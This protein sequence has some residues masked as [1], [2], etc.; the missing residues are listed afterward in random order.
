MYKRIIAKKKISFASLIT[1]IKH[2]TVRLGHPFGKHHKSDCIIE[3]QTLYSELT[4][5][6]TIFHFSGLVL[7]GPIFVSRKIETKFKQK[8]FFW[9]SNK[10]MVKAYSYFAE[11]PWNLR[12][13]KIFELKY[14][15]SNF[16][17]CKAA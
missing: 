1:Y 4:L 5:F 6:P 13:C 9:T 17:L 12:P 8:V 14:F 10:K 11:W 2:Q 7:V 16:F 3:D 15:S